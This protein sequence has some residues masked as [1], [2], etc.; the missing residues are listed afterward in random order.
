MDNNDSVNRDTLDD[1]IMQC[2]ADILRNRNKTKAPD[3]ENPFNRTNNIANR[4]SP[5]AANSVET[6]SEVA[7]APSTE[8][9]PLSGEKKVKI[10]LFE[11]L[12]APAKL[13]VEA[14]WET[15]IENVTEIKLENLPNDSDILVTP[16]EEAALF[17]VSEND[18]ALQDNTQTQESEIEE[19]L[20]ALRKVIAEANEEDEP[21]TQE[22]EETQITEEIP[23]IE[24]SEILSVEKE[25][26]AEDNGNLDAPEKMAV[27]KAE[28]EKTADTPEVIETQASSSTKIPEFNL[29]EKIL[30]EERQVASGRRQ[31]PPAGRKLNVMPIAG[32][33][34][35]IIK[36]A[37]RAVLRTEKNKES[38]SHTPPVQKPVE[39]PDNKPIAFDRIEIEKIEEVRCEPE[40]SM[41][42]CQVINDSD[43]LNPFQEDIIISIVSR[44]IARFCGELEKA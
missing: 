38:L 29:T 30:T 28:Q 21:E 34:G 25:N 23:N 26:I 9:T 24:A 17:P 18:Q 3:A 14:T 41:G 6:T 22:L 4:V 19:G 42:A 8:A 40:L 16:E 33:V 37:K 36:E 1:D 15:P 13:P 44:D 11:E 43:R 7:K 39:I 20:D 27:P 10:P 2:R 32:T 35:Q 12:I 5:S 31:R